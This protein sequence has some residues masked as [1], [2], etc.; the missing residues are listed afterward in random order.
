MNF[1]VC[2]SLWC[3]GRSKLKKFSAW[4]GYAL[5]L[6]GLALTQTFGA[7]TEHNSTLQPSVYEIRLP[8]SSDDSPKDLSAK[9]LR[10][11]MHRL[12]APQSI[13]QNATLE[14]A[15]SKAT[16]Y[17]IQ[18]YS[19]ITSTGPVTAWLFDGETVRALV[20][21]AGLRLTRALEISVWLV[22]EI[23]GIRSLV[24]KNN[25]PEL[26]RDLTEETEK[27]SLHLVFP[28][29]ATDNALPIATL[30]SGDMTSLVLA[31]EH[32]YGLEI[33]LLI[34][35]KQ[36]RD[37][38]W[39]IDWKLQQMQHDVSWQSSNSELRLALLDG[40]KSIRNYLPVNF[41]S[42]T[43]VSPSEVAPSELIDGENTV[44]PTIN[45]RSL[46]NK[47]A[48]SVLNPTLVN[49]D[50]LIPLPGSDAQ[51]LVSIDDT[52]KPLIE[53]LGIHSF[54]DLIQTEEYLESLPSVDDVQLRRL[55]EGFAAFYI[56]SS[57]GIE[58]VLR[59]I[60][61]GA[62]LATEGANNK[63]RFRLVR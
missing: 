62:F 25:A 24:T 46:L 31:G 41:S 61:L 40:I 30:W 29:G 17:V 1:S 34:R 16:S 43:H 2:S 19:E 54:L 55:D 23:Q 51:S 47:S 56:E 13:E 10:Q 6:W 21:K 57:A 36:T 9:A 37:L 4:W 49:P 12:V 52:Q 20:E 22:Y 15:F 58:T 60:V 26:I 53:I 50:G 18:Q 59:T 48:L 45:S 28:N 32:S 3:K 14:D 7:P 38:H 5:L 44:L 27:H 11:L 39:T 42:Q 63:N 8:S 33:F 35:A